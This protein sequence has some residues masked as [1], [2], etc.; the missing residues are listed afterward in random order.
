MSELAVDWILNRLGEPST[1][2]GIIGIVMSA[3]VTI[4]PELI[5]QIVAA[6]VGLISLINVFKRDAKSKDA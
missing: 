3:G 2:R 6:G 4:S 1:W 5:T